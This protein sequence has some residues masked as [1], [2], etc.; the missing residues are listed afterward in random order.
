M[1]Y[2]G[3]AGISVGKP[4]NTV[5]LVGEGERKE[6]IIKNRFVYVKKCLYEEEKEGIILTDV[7]R[8]NN[9]F[10]LVLAISDDCGKFH[11]L[12]KQQKKRGEVSQVELS[13]EPNMK[14]ILPDNHPWGIIRSPYGIDEFW[15]REDIIKAVLEE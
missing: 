9:V 12:T 2:N 5:V 3:L 1:Q 13:I 8:S 15:V 7:T 14:I 11:K 10:A 6:I 4:R